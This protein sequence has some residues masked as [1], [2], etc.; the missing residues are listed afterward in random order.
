[1]LTIAAVSLPK[2][3]VRTLTALGLVAGT[4]VFGVATAAPAQ[5]ATNGCSASV[6]GV[7]SGKL[8][9]RAYD[10]S[11]K[12]G[13][14]PSDR[15]LTTGKLPYTPISF[16]G[17]F[18]GAGDPT[19]WLNDYYVPS[20]DGKLREVTVQ[21]WVGTTTMTAKTH[22]VVATGFKPSIVA[23]D[24]DYGNVVSTSSSGLVYL[25]KLT[26]TY[27]ARK[28]GAA[29]LLPTKLTNPTTLAARHIGSLRIY[30]TSKATGD[31]TE[32]IV[33]D[34]HPEKAKAYRI[35]SSGFE[36]LTA[37]VPGYC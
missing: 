9:Y 13:T 34:G 18:G 17:L 31:L 32:I 36:T 33:P 4:A 1:M 2:R 21:H 22:Q 24:G 19:T 27:G 15:G 8:T 37:L 16:T 28:L 3:V 35:A 11:G 26:G 14:D 5:A 12:S 6:Y 23:I 25:R 29:V 20:T 30:S 10:Q 7:Q